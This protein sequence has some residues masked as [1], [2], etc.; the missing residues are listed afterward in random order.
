M[1]LGEAIYKA[2]AARGRGERRTSE[3]E[4]EDD[5][6]SM[7][8]SRNP[9]TMTRSPDPRHERFNHDT[10]RP[11]EGRAILPLKGTTDPNGKA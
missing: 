2:Q 5:G 1:K 8:I 9:G 4:R 7:P 3:P 6:W 10:A 11:R